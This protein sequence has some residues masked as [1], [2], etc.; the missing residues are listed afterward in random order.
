MFFRKG[1]KRCGGDLILDVELLPDNTYELACI[2]CG[3]R[4][5]RGVALLAG[6]LHTI[7]GGKAK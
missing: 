6:V 1:C 2:Q 4:E 5:H 7:R 3:F